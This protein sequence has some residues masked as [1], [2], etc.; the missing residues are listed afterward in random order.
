MK[1][2]AISMHEPIQKTGNMCFGDHKVQCY[3]ESWSRW[4]EG[5]KCSKMWRVFLRIF[6]W[7]ICSWILE[8]IESGGVI[9]SSLLS[10]V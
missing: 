8:W 9:T 6:L 10:C 1:L 7:K 3:E 5:H 4:L 2:T